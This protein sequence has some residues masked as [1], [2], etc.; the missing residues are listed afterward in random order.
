MPKVKSRKKRT[1]EKNCPCTLVAVV[2][3]LAILVVGAAW[4]ALRPAAAETPKPTPGGHLY[5][6]YINV[7][8]G[9]GGI[10]YL[11]EPNAKTTVVLYEDFGSPEMRDFVLNQEPAFV[12]GYVVPGFV[13]LMVYDVGI[14]SPEAASAAEA[15][16]C[17]ADQGYYWDYRN[18]LFRNQGKI[19]F[20]RDG[21][22]ALAKEAGMDVSA[23]IH[24]YDLNTHH[25]DVQA[26]TKNAQ[27]MAITRF[28]AW[29]IG[30]KLYEGVSS[31]ESN[32]PNH[33]GLRQLLAPIIMEAMRK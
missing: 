7:P 9:R 16:A 31:L 1:D 4:F 22:V 11:G 30:R 13:R 6:P 17:A 25:A 10:P 8:H 28:P 5:N 14:T 26:R 19:N 29:D 24:C 21:F 33:P 32:D 20:E 15:A 12:H 3:A 23:F 27:E 18:L 2:G